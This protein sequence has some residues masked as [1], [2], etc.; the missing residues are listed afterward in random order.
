MTKVVFKSTS[1][2][3]NKI[4]KLRDGIKKISDKQIFTSFA[5]PD[6]GFMHIFT[7]EQGCITSR[8]SRGHKVRGQ[9]HKKIQGQGQLLRGQNLSRARTEML[10]APRTQA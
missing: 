3:I 9:G 10:E 2:L 1:T 7:L 8:W 4:T 5:K 6:Q